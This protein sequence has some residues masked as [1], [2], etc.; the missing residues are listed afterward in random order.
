[1]GRDP[2]TA[3]GG[4][5]AGGRILSPAGR[6]QD[7]GQRL[8][9]GRIVG[10]VFQGGTQHLGRLRAPSGAEQQLG[11]AQGRRRVGRIG[12]QGFPV[13]GFGFCGAPQHLQHQGAVRQRPGA[14]RTGG[15]FEHLVEEGERA[16]RIPRHREGG[17]RGG[18][19]P[20]G[21]R[22]AARCQN[23]IE[24]RR[25][26]RR[27]PTAQ[28]GVREPASRAQRRAVQR[29][30][31][32]GHE[33]GEHAGSRAR[34]PGQQVHP[35][36]S[37]GEHRIRRIPDRG[38]LGHP[39]RL[40]EVSTVEQ[41]PQQFRPLVPA[42]FT[43]RR[44]QQVTTT[45]AEPAFLVAREEALPLVGDGGVRVLSEQLAEP[46]PRGGVLRRF[47]DGPP[48]PVNGF[49][50]PSEERQSA[51]ERMD[52]SGRRARPLDDSFE[53]GQGALVVVLLDSL[54]RAFEDRRRRLAGDR[55]T[56]D[57]ARLRHQA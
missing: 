48:E 4:A 31:G 1:M 13:T 34:I 44:E 55:R 32:P 43:E 11:E 40:R 42:P 50:A 57:A 21:N 47:R 56:K 37:D 9:K 35:G 46:E 38:R 5:R 10:R 51:A 33:R 3:G 27:V 54:P 36:L 22:V 26:G 6:R 7:P 52:G 8:E 41:E 12:F 19:N 18:A 23:A 24:Q 14:R 25:R 28:P 29:L 20:G 53:E 17:G 2:R 49:R 39:R 30:A 16:F 45:R 15:T